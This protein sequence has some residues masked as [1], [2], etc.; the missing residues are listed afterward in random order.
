MA[1]RLAMSGAEKLELVGVDEYLTS[2]ESVSTKS[3]YIDGWVR[4]M[5]GAT[6]RHN[7]V[8]E[9]CFLAI[10]ASL[11]GKP[12][13]PHIFDTKLRII[14]EHTKRFYYPDLQVVC[15][16]NLPSET[17]QDRPVL[18]LEVL[19]PTTRLY[20]LDEKLTAYTQIPSLQYY[21]ILEQHQPIAIL[22]RRCGSW[23]ERLEFQGMDR[24]IDLPRLGLSLALSA[25]Y[26][27]IEFTPTCVQEPEPQYQED[28][29]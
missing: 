1:R 8:T 27:G 3:E 21:L 23:F 7:R 24:S 6:N 26:E 18:V 29:S 2:Q 28:N 11:R 19:S 12:C 9:N 10:A 15:E 14:R 16:P 17:F 25:V 4:A 20:D 5:T 13:Q 22:Y